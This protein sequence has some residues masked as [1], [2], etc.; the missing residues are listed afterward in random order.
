MSLATIIIPSH[1]RAMFLEN[2]LAGFLL[3]TEQDFE[4]VV[5]DNAS[6][7]CTKNVI[8]K[9]ADKLK[10]KYLYHH[11]KGLPQREIKLL[12]SLKASIAY[13]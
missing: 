2:T 11:E 4:V 3:Q 12:I 8:D 9:Y 10:I 13:T 6:T 7:D 1:E 5:S